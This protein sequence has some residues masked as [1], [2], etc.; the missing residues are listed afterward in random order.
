MSNLNP[1]KMFKP[2][3]IACGELIKLL[4]KNSGM[5]QTDLA[6]AIG[7]TFQQVQK[8]ERGANRVS[9]SRL[10]VIAEALKVQPYELLPEMKRKPGGQAKS[11]PIL[12]AER[13]NYL[14]GELLRIRGITKEAV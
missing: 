7:I 14:E 6:N 11:L 9:V 1:K 13:I 2:V 10:Y 12:Q 3:D 4:R 5:S 8:Y